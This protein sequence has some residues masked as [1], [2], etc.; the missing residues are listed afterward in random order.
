MKDLRLYKDIATRT[1]GDIYIGVV[2]PV[3]RES[4]HLLKNSWKN[5]LYLILKMKIDKKEQ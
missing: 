2:G 3:E 1:N 5:L 4:L